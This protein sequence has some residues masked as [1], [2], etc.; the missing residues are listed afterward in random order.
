VRHVTKKDGEVTIVA[1]ED[2]IKEEWKRQAE[3]AWRA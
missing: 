2:P 3:A 1:A